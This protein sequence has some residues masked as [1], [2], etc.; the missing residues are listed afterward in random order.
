M[1]IV[2]FPQF[3]YLSEASR[4]VEIG[5]A[6]RKTGQDILFLSHGGTY[7]YVACDEGFEVVPVEPSM[8]PRRAEEYK[9]FNRAERGNPLKDSFFSYEELRAYVHSE[10]DVLRTIKADAVLIG[11]NLPSYLS[12]QLAGIPIIVQQPGPFTAP[13]FDKKMGIF[14]PSIVGWLRYLPMDWF[15]NWFLPRTKLWLGPFNRLASELG[16]PQ[17]RTLLD[18]MAGDLTLVMDTPGILGITPEELEHYKP[19]HP[20]FFHRQPVYR[21]GGACYAKLPGEIPQQVTEHFTTSR[22]KLY[23]GMGVSGSPQ[24]LR[25]VVDIVSDLDLQALIVTTTILGTTE[26]NDVSGRIMLMDHVPAHLVNPLADIAITHGGAG[27]IQTAI[28]SA[29]PLV[30]VPMHLEQAGNISLVTR[31][32]A[33][34]MLSRAELDRKKLGNALEHLLSDPSFR[35]N[36]QGLK[37]LQDAVDGAETAANQIVRFLEGRS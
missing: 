22:P 17:F 29:T 3:Y 16:L 33:G 12:V 23:C 30:G 6:L 11:W 36:M 19:S 14:V 4:L 5:K 24:V 31:R 21:Y 7:E 10:A 8:S 26:M 15:V 32:H 27:T 1:K 18:M 20:E 2:C 28:H 34:L 13:F 9:A 35:Q 25:E 37:Q